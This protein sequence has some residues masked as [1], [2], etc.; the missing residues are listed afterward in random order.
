MIKKVMLGI[1]FVI[2][3]YIV[4]AQADSVRIKA[5]ADSVS[6]LYQRYFKLEQETRKLNTIEGKLANIDNLT[7]ANNERLNNISEDDKITKKTQYAT[8]KGGLLNTAT[9]ITTATKSLQA[10]ELSTGFMNYSNFI[11][12][13]NNPQD[14][15][16]GFKLSDVVTKIVDEKIIKG[17]GGR[18]FRNRF[19]DIVSKVINNPIVSTVGKTMLSV[20]P[21]I[22]SLTS[23]FNL[24]NTA[25]L[26][27]EDIDTDSLQEFTKE[28]QKYMMHY[29][30][31]AK[32]TRELDQNLNNLKVKNSSLRALLTNFVRENIAD[33]YGE[34]NIPN[35]DKLTLTEMT[36]KYFNYPAILNHIN[37]I[38]T[39]SKMNYA[40][41]LQKVRFPYAI[42]SKV[43][44]VMEE[45]EK[46]YAEQ[47]IAFKSYNDNI[48]EVMTNAAQLGDPS[49]VKSKLAELETNY[50]DLLKV[51]NEN[52]QLENLRDARKNVPR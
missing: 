32:A 6:R 24:V 11:T 14:E 46:S 12:T 8:N 34:T 36:N 20:T 1:L 23:V 28:M 27:N 42:R 10:M 51:Y 47:L 3:P 17:K 26:T 40:V 4:S 50:R 44:F 7:Q 19:R 41:M 13:L 30:G 48:S 39:E 16:L 52:V 31:L 37:Q 43:A 22:S 33:L 45:I 38:E 18:R 2:S 5:L 25:A 29:E 9:F 21:V 35:L 15:S 49:K